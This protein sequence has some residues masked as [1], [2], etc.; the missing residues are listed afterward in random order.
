LSRKAKKVRDKWRSKKWFSVFS[1]PYFGEVELAT[2]PTTDPSG[3]LGKTIETT[4]YDV[5]K[6]FSHQ[7]IGIVFQVSGVEGNRA[8]TI[9][10]GHEYARDYLRSLIRR[11]GSRVDGIFDVVTKE[12]YKVRLSVIACALRRVNATQ[13]NALRFTMKRVAEEKALNLTFDQFVQEAVLGKLAS[14]IYNEA[15]RVAPLRH[16][17]IRKS[18]LIAQPSPPQVEAKAKLESPAEKPEGEKPESMTTMQ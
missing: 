9:F 14:D 8:D 17:G 4:L 11:G 5:T 7:N 1:P 6:D 18:K 2:V 12:G 15:K 3:I 16:V 10:K 13:S